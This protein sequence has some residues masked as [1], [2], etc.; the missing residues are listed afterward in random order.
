MGHMGWPD[1]KELRKAA[2]ERGSW[3]LV[4]LLLLV[5]VL[6]ELFLHRLLGWA[7]EQLD[8]EAGP[9][10]EAFR[11]VLVA[12]ASHR[13]IFALALAVLYC[14][15]VVIVAQIQHTRSLPRPTAPKDTA[16]ELGTS[17]ILQK[18]LTNARIE[19]DRL[20]QHRI[21]LLG[22]QIVELKEASPKTPTTVASNAP[23]LLVDY[24]D[25]GQKGKLVFRCDRVAIIR[26]VH[27]LISRERYQSEYQFSLSPSIPPPADPAK[28]V[29]CKIYGLRAANRP[30]I[31]SLVD[32][33]RGESEDTLD[34]VV[35]DYDDD[36]GNQ[37]C[38]RY[39][40]FKGQDGSVS[41]IPDAAIYLR[42]QSLLSPTL[43]GEI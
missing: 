35:V 25:T 16:E 28:P 40:L 27:P 17:T 14:V 42:V 36:H 4:G 8:H 38:R 29:E 23:R 33:L 30:D 37:Y 41:W 34:S 43:A 31:R 1:F 19:I 26:Q 7:N 20:N 32:I 10:I 15:V 24:A 2:A 11:E 12:V 22:S 18:E 3:W 39:S 21:D 9:M 6:Q 13:F 5:E